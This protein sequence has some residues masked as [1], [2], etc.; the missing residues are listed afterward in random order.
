MT[1][2]WSRPVKPTLPGVREWT[3]GVQGRSDLAVGIL[4][5]S[6]SG[7]GSGFVPVPTS[8]LQDLDTVAQR[9]PMPH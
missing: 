1:A 9:P 3:C 6:V 8:Q 5:G 2:G 7:V 4:Q